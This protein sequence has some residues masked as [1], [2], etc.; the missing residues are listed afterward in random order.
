MSVAD[1]Q[2]QSTRP[3][4]TTFTTLSDRAYRINSV[5]YGPLAQAEGARTAAARRAHV[6]LFVLTPKGFQVGLLFCYFT[7]RAVRPARE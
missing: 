2:S 6:R 3:V 4:L 7:K 5:R 1:R